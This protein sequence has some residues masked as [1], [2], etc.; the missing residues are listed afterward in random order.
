[1]KQKA[2]TLTERWKNKECNT[3]NIIN[4]KSNLDKAIRNCD[5]KKK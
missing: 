2:V 4:K 1:M 5:V 3:L